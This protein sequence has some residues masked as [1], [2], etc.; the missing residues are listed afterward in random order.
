MEVSHLPPGR[1]GL[2]QG[3]L[4]QARPGAVGVAG[5]RAHLR[6]GAVVGRGLAQGG[7]SRTAQRHR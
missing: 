2:A 1:A 6:E 4:L 7:H 5:W 3:C